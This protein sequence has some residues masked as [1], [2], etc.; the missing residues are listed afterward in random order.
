MARSNFLF[1]FLFSLFTSLGA[2]RILNTDYDVIVIGGGPAGLSAVSA[3][4]RVGRR[5]IMFDSQEYRNAPTRNMHDVIGN[6][7]QQ[8][9]SA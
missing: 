2:T 7:G 9:L 6:D 8:H 5:V 1:L 3:L 4:C